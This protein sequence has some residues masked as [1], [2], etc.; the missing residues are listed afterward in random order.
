MVIRRHKISLRVLKNISRVGG[1][2]VKD[3]S[4]QEEKF[5]ILMWPCNVLFIM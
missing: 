4:K 1:S 5:C 2:E 3:S